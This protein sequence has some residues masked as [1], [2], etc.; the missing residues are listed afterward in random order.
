M[1]WRTIL[2]PYL[3]GWRYLIDQ[4]PPDEL[5]QAWPVI[6]KSIEDG[7]SFALVNRLSALVAVVPHDVARQF[8][9]PF[10][11]KLASMA[12]YWFFGLESSTARVAISFAIENLSDSSLPHSTQIP[13]STISPSALPAISR[14]VACFPQLSQLNARQ[15]QSITPPYGN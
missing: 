8:I 9:T 7:D 6:V 5:D 2:L 15:C 14:I 13:A 11:S 3:L 1:W 4:L 12:S 10:G